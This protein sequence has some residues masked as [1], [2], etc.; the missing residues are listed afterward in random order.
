MSPEQLNNNCVLA[1]DIWSFG[2]LYMELITSIYGA[3]YPNLRHSPTTTA[4]KMDYLQKHFYFKSFTYLEE[5]YNLLPPD[6]ELWACIKFN[7]QDRCTVS[8]LIKMFQT[9]ET[10][11]LFC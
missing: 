3:P 10:K 4:E 2:I 5:T 9:R 8:D 1:S 7:P 6:M 11:T